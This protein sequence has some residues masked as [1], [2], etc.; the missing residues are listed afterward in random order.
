MREVYNAP[1]EHDQAPQQSNGET[2]VERRDIAPQE[3]QE[4]LYRDKL[5]R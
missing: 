5:P 1:T 3:P 4:S 2:Q